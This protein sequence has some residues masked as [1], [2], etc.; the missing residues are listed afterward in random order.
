MKNIFRSIL[1]AVATALLLASAGVSS[2][3]TAQVARPSAFD[4]N[5]SVVIYTM[6]GDCTQSVRAA[7]RIA[8]GRVYA[9]DQSFQAYGAVGPS[10]AIR[11]T[12][13]AGNQSANGTG[14]LSQTTGRGLWRTATGECS[15]QWAAERR[16]W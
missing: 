16:N 11:V 3:A 8:G 14:R 1:L 9:L 4:G 10:G 15:G 5:W 2:G 12:V 7:L 13:A 6:R